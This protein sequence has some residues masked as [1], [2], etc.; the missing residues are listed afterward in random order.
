MANYVLSFRGQAGRT[1]SA[2]EEAEWTAWFGKIGG[3]IAD[4]GHRVSR[5]R[6]VGD[7]VRDRSELAG[8]VVITAPDLDAAVALAE[9]CP[10]LRHAGGVEVGEV[11]A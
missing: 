5:A 3:S 2:D 4:F 8:Y 7:G 6:T 11:M 1:V 10:G 9:G